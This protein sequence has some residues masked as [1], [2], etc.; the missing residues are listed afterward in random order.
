MAIFIDL[1]PCYSPLN[2]TKLKCSCKVTLLSIVNLLNL[3]VLV[4]SKDILFRWLHTYCIPIPM[5][6]KTK[7]ELNRCVT[8]EL[9]LKMTWNHIGNKF[10]IMTWFYKFFWISL[11]EN[12]FRFLLNGW[13]MTSR[14]PWTNYRLGIR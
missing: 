7:G 9:F 13:A 3:W 11:G 2:S 10:T 5:C 12:N 4:S 14:G 1:W 6:C 8:L